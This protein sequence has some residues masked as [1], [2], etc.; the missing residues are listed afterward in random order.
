MKALSRDR[1]KLNDHFDVSHVGAKFPK[2]AADNQAWLRQ[3]LG[4]AITHRRQF[5][6]YT[7]EHRDGENSSGI[8]DALVV[9][10][11]S[12]LDGSRLPKDGAAR[13]EGA[14][15][16]STFFTK[17]TTI[18]PAKMS[19]LP[20]SLDQESDAEDD[21]K[22]YTTISRSVDDDLET[23]ISDR[24]PKLL[25]LQIALELERS[26]I[27]T[28]PAN[29]TLYKFAALGGL[30][31]P[32]S[33]KEDGFDL[34]A[35]DESVSHIASML[36]NLTPDRALQIQRDYVVF[37]AMK[38]REFECPFCCEIKK[39]KDEKAW[40][41]HVYADLRPYVCTFANCSKPYF[42]DLNEWFNHE[43][44]SHRVSYA[45]QLCE[46]K[47]YSFDKQYLDHLRRRHP[48]LLVG[49]DEQVYLDIAKKP[50]QQILA[51]DCPCC[52]DWTDRLRLRQPGIEA[53]EPIHVTPAVFKRHL[54]S[55]LEQL[56]LFALPLPASDNDGRGSK[57]ALNVE[58]DKDGRSA[59][60][61][62][63]SFDSRPPS[64][65]EEEMENVDTKDTDGEGGKRNVTSDSDSLGNDWDDEVDLSDVSEGLDEGVRPKIPSSNRHQATTA[66][67]LKASYKRKTCTL[68]FKNHVKCQPGS[69]DNPNDPSC[70]RCRGL[71]EECSLS[72]PRP[73]DSLPA[74]HS[75]QS[76]QE[77][78]SA[79][80]PQDDEKVKE[81][82]ARLKSIGLEEHQAFRPQAMP[83]IPMTPQERQETAE[84]LQRF[85]IDMSKI[86]RGLA[87]WYYITEDDDRARCF[88]RTVSQHIP[89]SSVCLKLSETDPN[90]QRL[91]I[92]QQFADREAMSVPKDTFSID[93]AELDQSRVL[94]ESMAKD[95]ARIVFGRMVEADGPSCSP[96]GH[97]TNG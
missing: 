34:T 74:M 14:S 7:R 19:S 59:V 21:A 92:I 84:K 24:V 72:A 54:A 68:C 15:R 75:T 69:A 52:T 8:D 39:I 85:A 38:K 73:S 94:L 86:G 71:G 11:G 32:K 33:L 77:D 9:G 88:F 41:R 48:A 61:S 45:C 16:P 90:T 78:Q 3:R 13:G 58:T 23:S 51:E 47:L 20:L 25:D 44:K 57:V 28:E 1:L 66:E 81:S 62:R 55:H 79:T 27:G 10:V 60:L 67:V 50:V 37:Q 89:H 70:A 95:L 64:P 26:P 93:Y 91:R 80:D 97:A 56:A 87:K 63:V 83:D 53:S 35:E 65:V 4:R 17:A 12:R 5:L 46:G 22:S 31:L 96:T 49:S 40:R 2:L 6:R 29:R 82:F 36:G 42:G 76:A 30:T 18:D 43:M